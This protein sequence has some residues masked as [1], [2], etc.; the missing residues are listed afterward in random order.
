VCNV[1]KERVFWVEDRVGSRTPLN[2][3]MK[4]E[5]PPHL[6]GIEPRVPVTKK[7]K[8]VLQRRKTKL[9]IHVRSGHLSLVILRLLSMCLAFTYSAVLPRTT[10]P[11]NMENRERGS[12]TYSRD[13]ER[14][15]KEVSRKRSIS[16]SLCGSSMRG[17]WREGSFTGDSEGN[18]S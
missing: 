9:C 8:N 6:Q 5:L 10:T 16:L 15:I 18:A 1:C 4:R 14:G 7:K 2:T 12:Y 3:V 17:T 13:F 11:N